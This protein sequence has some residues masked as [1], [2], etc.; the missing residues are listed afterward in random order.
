MGSRVGQAS[1][2]PFV[3][4]IKGLL[5]IVKER[6]QAGESQGSSAERMS[7]FTSSAPDRC[8]FTTVR[9]AEE[10]KT[11]CRHHKHPLE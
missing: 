1:V 9:P 10:S 8:A 7:A 3:L 5:W 6:A 2:A 11:W 4:E